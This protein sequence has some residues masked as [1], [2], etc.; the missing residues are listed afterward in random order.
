MDS[1]GPKNHVLDGVQIPMERGNFDRERGG[2]SKSTGVQNAIH[3]CG[4]DSLLSNY[5]DHLF[6]QAVKIRSQNI[7][8]GRDR[9]VKTETGFRLVS[10]KLC[11]LLQF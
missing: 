6:L 11:A 1:N 2:P 5:F 8:A 9:F 7:Y 10:L 3:M 4:G